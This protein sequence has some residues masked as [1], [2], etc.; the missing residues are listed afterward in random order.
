MSYPF[1]EIE[2]K[3]QAYWEKNDSFATP[4]TIEK[5]KY[6]ILD[7]FPYPSGAGLHVGHPEG[8]T[9][10]DIVARYKRMQ[11]FHVL[12]PMGWDAYGLPAER[13]AMETGIHPAITTK[14]NIDTFRRQ[15]KALGFSYDWKREINTTNADYY[16]WTQ[17]IFLKI[18]QSFYDEKQQRA[19]PISELNIPKEIAD[20][21]KKR[22]QYI[23]SK[24]LAYLCEASVNWC[25]EINAV[26]ANEEVEE[27]TSKG[28]TV[29]RRPMQQWMLRITAY[30]ERL[31]ADLKYLDWPKG[32]LELQKN[33]IGRS[34]G[35]QIHFPLTVDKKEVLKVFT[36]RPDTVFGVTYLVVAPEHPLVEPSVVNTLTTNKQKKLV[37]A[38][39]QATR[40]RS[41]RERIIAGEKAQKTGVFTG[42]YAYHPF[43]NEKLPIWIA[44]YVLMSYGSGIVMAVPAHDERD[45]AFA[46]AFQL[47]IKQVVIPAKQATTKVN[48]KQ[49]EQAELNQAY[50]QPGINVH[51]DFLDGLATPQAI[52]KVTQELVKRKLGKSQVNYKLRDWLFSRQRYWGEPIPISYDT[53]G[54]YYAL[55]EKE[56]PLHLPQMDCL[57]A[58]ANTSVSP[59]AR[60]KEWLHHKGSHA[61]DLLRETNTMPQWAG[62][63][64]YYL[65]FIDPC[66]QEEFV[67]P[68]KESYWMG[69]N[70]V[71]LYVGG[72][73]HAVLH[74]LYARFWHKILYDLGY[75]STPEPFHKLVHQGL[76]LGEDGNKMSKSLGNVVNPDSVVKEYGA[77][78]FRL[79]EMFLGPLEQ[80][81]PWSSRG[82]EGVSRFLNRVWRLFTIEV[83]TE[84]TKKGMQKEN[85]AK[86]KVMPKDNKKHNKKHMEEFA[87]SS[88]KII[89]DP[90]LL[91][92]TPAD[93]AQKHEQLLHS[94]IKK[95]S[96]DIEKLAFNTAI[97]SLMNF[98]NQVYHQ[99]QLGLQSASS[100][101]LLLSPFA[102]HLAEELWSLLRHKDSLLY[103]AWPK[104]DSTKI[105]T[106]TTEIVLQVNG[107]VRSKRVVVLNT[108]EKELEKIAIEDK[109]LQRFIGNQPI[110]RI[111]FVKNRL[112]NVV[113]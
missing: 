24:R 44:D 63:C 74:L 97:A 7:M 109:Q 46:K 56:L 59:L 89:I 90:K 102:P 40:K 14:Q 96:E 32:T 75:V 94:T 50:V 111:V 104:Y 13:Y 60:A 57:Q 83:E 3:W 81:K 47:P 110:K 45:F 72:A 84:E 79:F 77:D 61:E 112:V 71:D 54:N 51:S 58:D 11:G 87:M 68:K 34:E 23:D 38:Y 85:K 20:D 28:Y 101:V 17:W 95:V 113:V 67:N 21:P 12:H 105:A 108:S 37:E 15:L 4:T 99:K 16:R 27:W 55:S 66:N 48:I 22:K 103:T 92:E 29:E 33:W 36:T 88:K 93:L 9:A 69:K 53:N 76:I 62:S 30:A 2:N 19:R 10:T 5:P 6:Y 1:Q 73:E 100:F 18:F 80:S 78:S 39:L 107:K 25:P 91:Q 106:D 26:L 35:A 43:T 64:W 41:E 31:L 49:L 65:R 8:Y 52:Q 42:S 86:S 82:I 98:V 70:G